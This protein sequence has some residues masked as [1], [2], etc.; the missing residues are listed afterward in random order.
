MASTP[1]AINQ[2]PSAGASFGAGRVRFELN[3]SQ[4][5]ERRRREIAEFTKATSFVSAILLEYCQWRSAIFCIRISHVSK[6]SQSHGRLRT[7]RESRCWKVQTIRR[8][9]V[10]AE[11][12]AGILQHEQFNGRSLPDGTTS[13]LLSAEMHW[14]SVA[15]PNNSGENPRPE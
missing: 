10:E 7:A 1:N 9:A 2:T 4:S 15:A 13:A 5:G 14:C 6:K 3:R 12:S 8:A 11:M